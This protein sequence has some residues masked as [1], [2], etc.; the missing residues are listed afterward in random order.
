MIAVIQVSRKGSGLKVT[1]LQIGGIRVRAAGQKR[2]V[3]DGD[4]E[5][6]T[7][8]QWLVAYGLAKG[9]KKKKGTAEEKKEKDVI[10]SLS[11]RV[12]ADMWLKPMRNP[13]VRIL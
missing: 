11:A 4:R 3:W 2:R 6:L 13:D 10:W 8:M 9:A 12:M 1:S 7:A 5:R